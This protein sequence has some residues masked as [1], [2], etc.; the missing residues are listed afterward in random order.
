MLCFSTASL[1]PV[2]LWADC[3]VDLLLW[4]SAWR[5]VIMHP[6]FDLAL[7]L[8]ASVSGFPTRVW[9]WLPPPPETCGTR[10]RHTLRTTPR[11]LLLQLH[12]SSTFNDSCVTHVTKCQRPWRAACVGKV[13]FMMECLRL[14]CSSFEAGYIKW[15]LCEEDLLACSLESSIL[16]G[17][18][19]CFCRT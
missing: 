6:S 3:L 7:R 11:D 18:Q 1:L 14:Q 15:D 8:A 19:R 12:T 4:L 13:R 17:L 5:N 9:L 16:R 2:F 10:E